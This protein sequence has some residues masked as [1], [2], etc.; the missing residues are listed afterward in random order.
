MET[1]SQQFQT[2]SQLNEG[3]QTSPPNA[4]N[5]GSQRPS[6]GS[7]SARR[8]SLT[9]NTQRLA[10]GLGWFSIGLGVTELF[11]PQFIASISGV[12]KKHT[13]L[14]RLYGLREIAAG[15]GIFAQKRPAESMWSR[16]A[17]DALDLASLGAVLTSPDAKRGRIA[18]ATAAVLGVTALDL[19]CAQQLSRGDRGIHAHKSLIVNCSPDEAYS[20]WRSFSNLPRFMKHLESVHDSGEGRSHWVAKGPAGMTVE[21]DAEIIADRPGELITWHSLPGSDVSNAGAV[22]FEKAPGN[23]GT[24]VKVN[25]EYDPPA[26]VI[27]ATVA[28]L[29]GEE[30]NQQLDDD[31]RRFK[32]VMELGEVVVSE[33]TLHGTG[34]LEQRPGQPA[35]Q[36]EISESSVSK[37][38]ESEQRQEMQ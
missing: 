36:T 29:L 14:I 8:S 22:I 26:G 9:E 11:A 33:A 18:F 6:N 12:P 32:Q 5:R 10:R 25:L 37:W 23:R 13:A 24:I 38:N 20:F 21:W 19:V 28:R 35:T 2:P 1:K 7:R 17:G 15:V 4:P 34:Y 31:L 16:V 30:P 27:G 3:T